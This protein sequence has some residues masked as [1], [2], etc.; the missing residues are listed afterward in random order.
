MRKFRIFQV[1][2]VL[3]AHIC[4]IFGYQFVGARIAVEIFF[5]I[6]GFYIAL[7][8][9]HNY[10]S[11]VKRFYINRV[12]RAYPMYLVVFVSC[13]LI[14][15]ANKRIYRRGILFPFLSD[16]FGKLVFFDCSFILLNQV[17]TCSC[18][19]N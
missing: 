10:K 12:L 3:L 5:I 18:G 19:K 2:T 14:E 13:L 8:L 1:L 11:P 6:S 9:E 16:N 7:I 15:F 4:G 17:R